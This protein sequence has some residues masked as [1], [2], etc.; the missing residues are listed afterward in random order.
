[1]PWID[2]APNVLYRRRYHC[3]VCD[4]T[5][6]MRHASLEE[7]MPDCPKCVEL[8]K[9]AAGSA[10]V[11]WIPPHPA[12]GTFKGKSIDLAQKIAEED[13]GMTNMRD[14]QRPGDTAF[15]PDAPMQTAEA[16]KRLREI[17]EF[18]QHAETE[19]PA[20]TGPLAPDGTRNWL[21]DPAAQRDNFFQGNMGGTAEETIGQGAAAKA[22]SEAARADGV[23]PVGLLE[24]GKASGNMPL[25][26]KVMGAVAASDL[27]E[28]LQRAQA[29]GG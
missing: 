21:T 27:P 15:L 23:D 16:E 19:L 11:G 2:K 6:D 10:A 7:P 20:P 3:D 12:I 1:M 26:L 29:A 13:Y 17:M 28:P 9:A 8:G 4:H 22:A 25:R 5:F 14:N 24:R 18:T